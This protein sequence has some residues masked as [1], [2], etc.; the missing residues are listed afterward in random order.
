MA[1]K[2]VGGFTE[3]QISEAFRKLR[4]EFGAMGWPTKV[5]HC[6]L[7]HTCGH[8]LRK[9]L[10]GE[11]W[12]DTCGAYRRYASH[13]WGGNGEGGQWCPEVKEREEV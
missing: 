9:V 6:G 11:E 10:D 12:C 3:Q 4:A 7:C 2:G 13:G 5:T 1:T 8:E